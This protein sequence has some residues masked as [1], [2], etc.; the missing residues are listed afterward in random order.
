[1]KTLQIAAAL[2]VIGHVAWGLDPFFT[3]EQ[4]KTMVE[5]YKRREALTPARQTHGIPFA[6]G[7]EQ[8][9]IPSVKLQGVSLVQAVNF[10]R[11]QLV[12]KEPAFIDVIWLLDLHSVNNG[13][14][15]TLDL[16]D[17]PFIEALR[18]VTELA[19]VGYC[20]R[21]RE[22]TIGGNPTFRGQWTAAR[23][24]NFLLSEALIDLWLP[25]KRSPYSSAPLV[26]VEKLLDGLGVP[27]GV[28]AQADF[29][30]SMNAL[31]VFNC[32][33]ALWCLDVLIE[34]SEAELI[35][36]AALADSRLIPNGMKMANLKI[37]DF[38]HPALERILSKKDGLIDPKSVTTRNALRAQGIIFPQG[39]IAWLD[40]KKKV[41]HV[42]SRPE[43]I[44]NIRSMLSSD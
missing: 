19:G 34:E 6:L 16:K 36:K 33:V 27:F 9:R 3:V 7:I 8:V 28:G 40:R 15:I 25:G 4:T 20:I 32:E 14:A 30:P 31:C 2:S 43:I 42:M 1:M 29:V 12:M 24:K 21:G 5:A 35:T 37:S 44:T 17:Q 41:L 39:A 18:Y 22:I 23:P 10:L 38:V 26:P 11:E 13:S